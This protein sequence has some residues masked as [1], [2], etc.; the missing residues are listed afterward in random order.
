MNS[1]EKSRRVACEEARLLMVPIWAKDT[2]VTEQEKNTFEA[3]ITM[4]L[5]CRSEYEET[6]QIMSIVKEHWGPTSEDTLELIE[7]AGQSYTPKMTVEEGWEDL[8]R[9]CPG[10]A[11]TTERPKSL[12]LFLRIGAVAACLVIGILTWMIFSNYPKSLVLPTNSSS[13]QIASAPKS[14]VKVEMVTNTG[15]I[16]IPSYQQIIS[17]G[18]LKCSA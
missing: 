13:H 11:E 7:K 14:S 16:P 5:A 18:Q 3:H 2:S 12:Q 4:C 15:N 8:C 10:L 1:F 17:T 9:R 6:C